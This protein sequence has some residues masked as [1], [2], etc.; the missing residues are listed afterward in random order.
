MG[1]GRMCCGNDVEFSKEVGGELTVKGFDC[2]E[3]RVRAP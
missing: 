2:Y 3:S 1:K